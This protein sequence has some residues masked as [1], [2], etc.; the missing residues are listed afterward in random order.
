MKTD[1]FLTV[2]Q[3]A[4]TL[5]VRPLMIY[6]LVEQGKLPAIRIGRIIRFDPDDVAAFLASVRV[7]LNGSK[8]GKTEGRRE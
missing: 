3:L 1:P 8:E 7:G 2:R 4:D 5:A 6:R